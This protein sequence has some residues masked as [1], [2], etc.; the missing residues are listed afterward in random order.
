MIEAV[1]LAVALVILLIGSYTD[2]KT[3]EVPDWVNIAGIFIGIGLRALW[4]LSGNG[5]SELGFGMVGFILFFALSIIMY[6]AGQWGGGDSKLLMAMGALLGF[7]FSKDS[8]GVGFLLWIILAGA[9]YGMAC[10]TFLAL[11]NFKSFARNYKI[12]FEKVKW[13]NLPAL[14]VLVFGFA[15]AIATD[16]H[17][18][19]VLLLV[20]ALAV[21]VLFYLAVGVKAVEK[22]CMFRTISPEFLTE[23]D[24]IAKPVTY[25]GKYLCGPKDLGVTKEKIREL[26]RLGIKQVMVKDG[27]PFVPSFLLA[28]LMY[29]WLGSPLMWFL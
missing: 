2:I 13:A 27:V 17:F 21:P 5:W 14:A 18:L 9:F 22:C 23:G 3:R 19:R 6:Y 26:K 15:F 8:A 29:L 10:S 11:K 25:K 12:I 28:F 16:D 7:W 24:W 4:G 20:I 1:V